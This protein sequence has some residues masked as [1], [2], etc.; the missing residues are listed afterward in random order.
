MNFK[1]LQVFAFFDQRLIQQIMRTFILLCCTTVFAFSANTGNSQDAKIRIGNDQ[2]A[3]VEQIF[4][5]IKEQTDY[6]FVFNEKHLANAPKVY[7]EKGTAKASELLKKGLDPIGCTYEFSNNTIVVKRKTHPV[8]NVPIQD[9]FN[10]SGTVLDKSGDPIPGISVYVLSKEP[11]DVSDPPID[12]IVNG[13]ATDLDGNFT[14]TVALDHFLVVSGIGYAHYSEK[15]SSKKGSY[16]I[17]LEDSVDQLEEVILTGYQK[18]AKERSAANATTLS[19]KQIENRITTDVTSRLEGLVPGLIL[20]ND[21]EGELSIDIGGQTT[22]GNQ[23][24]LIVVDGFPI[25]EG[26]NSVNPNDIE[27]ISFLKDASASAIYGARASNGVIVIVT[28]SAKESGKVTISYSSDLI[29]SERQPLSNLHQASAADMVEWRLEALDL[30]LINYESDIVDPF[31]FGTDW[32]DPVDLAYFNLNG[33]P[34]FNVPGTGTQQEFDAEIARLSNVDRLKEIRDNLY[35]S[36]FIQ[37]HSL[38]L[39][40][41]SDKNNFYASFLYEDAPSRHV[42]N[43]RE[44]FTLNLRDKV[45]I[46]KK[47]DLELGSTLSFISGNNNNPLRDDILFN[48]DRS[49]AYTSIIDANGNLL[50]IDG[51][52]NQTRVDDFNNLGYVKSTYNPV[53]DIQ[54]VD[55]TFNNVSMR[56]FAKLNFKITDWLNVEGRYSFQRFR[57]AA[58]NLTSADAYAIRF[59]QFRFTSVNPD[60]SLNSLFP[61]GGRLTE[62]NSLNTRHVYGGQ[63]NVDKSFKN[64]HRLTVI[65]GI[66]LQE[67]K[68]SDRAVNYYGYDDRSLTFFDFSSSEFSISEWLNRRVPTYTGRPDGFEFNILPNFNEARSRIFGVYSNLNYDIDG[69]YI[70]TGSG[71]IDGASLLGASERNKT[72]ILW[73]AGGAWN[74]HNED[75]FKSSWI[76]Q[77][78][79][80]VTYGFTA[81]PDPSTTAFLVVA[82]VPSFFATLLLDPV[83]GRPVNVAAARPNPNLTWETTKNFNVGLD[84]TLFNNRLSG[85]VDYYT[86]KSEDLLVRTEPNPTFG[87]GNLNPAINN[88]VLENRGIE[89]ALNAQIIRN[90]NFR[91][92]SYLTFAHNKNEIIAADLIGNTPEQY[93]IPGVSNYNEFVQGFPIDAFFSFRYAGLDDQGLPQIYSDAHDTN[94][95]II[96]FLTYRD[97]EDPDGAILTYQT[98]R[99]TP[100]FYGG[101]TNTFSYKNFELAFLMSYKLGHK[102][103]RPSY[104]FTRGVNGVADAEIANRWRQP[105]DEATTNVPGIAGLPSLPRFLRSSVPFRLY[106]F[107]DAVIEDASHIRLSNISLKYNVSD[108]LVKNIGLTGA[109]ITFQAN[110][111]G[112]L[113]SANKDFDPDYTGQQRTPRTLSFNNREIGST[114][115]SRLVP[116][117]Q[118]ILGIR[119]NF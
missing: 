84:F 38:S 33:A 70:I 77:L 5:L 20:N 68:T 23:S 101:L 87:L 74:L 9:T 108:Q 78:K 57:G 110:N 61:V 22:F 71:R 67:S 63:F 111:L 104:N 44:T 64:D 81:L 40:T 37:R 43:D 103:R 99:R 95:P 85:S 31:G 47:L 115:P 105:G 58:S 100:K 13:V 65:G 36:S 48:D 83:Y 46:S 96:D 94:S 109:S 118:F 45:T 97:L 21:I 80:R 34:T 2:T 116:A 54:S 35:R 88:G 39:S 10:I 41:G 82:R 3:S 79:P 66:E 15:I 113:W 102:F 28:K 25:Q 14:L 49:R 16:T 4:N 119:A 107:S 1:L 98:G 52:V 112:L 106:N 6:S 17:I 60:N 7:L 12:L 32:S 73:S 11:T 19:T 69:K 27:S 91:W 26:I 90:D 117:K 30:G 93:A 62:S 59:Q 92:S 55:N 53:E 51:V 56:M 86:K 50:P 18:I 75:F 24:P 42:G 76:D 89:V 114:G 8:L 29:A 72:T